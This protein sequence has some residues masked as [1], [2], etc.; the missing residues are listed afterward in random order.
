MKA[1]KLVNADSSIVMATVKAMNRYERRNRWQVCARLPSGYNWRKGEEY[2][3]TLRRFWSV[4]DPDAA[5]FQSS[6]R[7]KPWSVEKKPA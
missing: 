2:E 4:P 1:C 3:D 7:Q 5:Y 6:G